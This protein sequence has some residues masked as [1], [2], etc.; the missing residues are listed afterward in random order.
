MNM[1]KIQSV[2]LWFIKLIKATRG[3]NVGTCREKK[4][5]GIDI[6]TAAGFVRSLK[7]SNAILL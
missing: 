1:H 5:S 3:M 4:R 7:V 6:R 2:H